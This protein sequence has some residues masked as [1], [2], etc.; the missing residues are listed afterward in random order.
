MRPR[1]EHP[2]SSPGSRSSGTVH[3]E[4]TSCCIVTM[5]KREHY[6]RCS[7]RHSRRGGV[8]TAAL[9]KQ[10]ATGLRDPSPGRVSFPATQMTFPPP[11]SQHLACTP[12]APSCTRCPLSPASSPE[13]CPSPSNTT[14]E[15]RSSHREPL[16]RFPD[17]GPRDLRWSL[18]G[19]A[20]QGDRVSG[21]MTR[22]TNY[23]NLFRGWKQS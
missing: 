16:G 7:P 15:P 14:P 17:E 18:H 6:R 11:P 10:R 2:A 8:T 20:P 12:H 23:T 9:E 4:K 19:S 1:C 5:A 13:R 22:S 21:E 3:A